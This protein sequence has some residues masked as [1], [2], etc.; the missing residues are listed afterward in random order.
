MDHYATLGLNKNASIDEIKKAYRQLAKKWHP[1]KNQG[2]K[3]AEDKFKN[4]S[5]AYVVLSDPAKKKQYDDKSNSSFKYGF[6]DFVNSFSGSQFND[7]RKRSN[8]KTRQTQGRTHSMPKV[9][10]DHLDITVECYVP[11]R[12]AF[13]GKKIELEFKRTKIGYDNVQSYFM[14]DE[15]KTIAFDFDLKKMPFTIKE[16]DGKYTTTVRLA[17]LGNE[18]MQNIVNIWGEMESMPLCGDSLIKIWLV[19]EQSVS[20]DD[21]NVIHR[22]EAP[23]VSAIIENEKIKVEAVNGKKY[24]ASL[25]YPKNLSKI[26]FSVKNE[27]LA[28]SKTERGKYI[29]KID[30]TMPQIEEM[31]DEIKSQIK[32]LFG[33]VKE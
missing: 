10:T 27:G 4:I 22:I 2:S 11:I 31:T 17:K 25:N 29:V 7:W 30:I 15:Q 19:M 8:D 28:L 33:L 20:I 26:E 13:A 14:E 18:E 1:D 21:K 23:F 5:D 12:E 9:T 3:E 24:E 6:D 16:E 32:N